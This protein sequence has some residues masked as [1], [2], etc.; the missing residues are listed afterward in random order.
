MTNSFE[1]I[2]I[3]NLTDC[4]EKSNLTC[5]KTKKKKKLMQATNYFYG[6]YKNINILLS[7]KY[8]VPI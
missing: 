7:V 2:I 8:R 3:Y 6:F 5:L 1:F 4:V